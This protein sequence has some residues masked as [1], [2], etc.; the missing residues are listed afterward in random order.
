MVGLVYYLRIPFALY[1]RDVEAPAISSHPGFG[2]TAS[3][4]GLAALAALVLGFIP[5]PLIDL[6]RTASASLF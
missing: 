6:A 1:D 4:A 5:T 3:V 2:L